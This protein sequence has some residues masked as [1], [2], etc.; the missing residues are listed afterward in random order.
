MYAETPNHEKHIYLEFVE[1]F[2]ISKGRIGPG[3]MYALYAQAYHFQRFSMIERVIIEMG[4]SVDHL[5]FQWRY[6]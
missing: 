4:R 3:T 1:G 2:F 5:Y 6:R